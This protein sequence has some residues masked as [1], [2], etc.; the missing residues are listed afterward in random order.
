MGIND[1]P[2]PGESVYRLRGEASGD[3]VEGHATRPGLKATE[4][5]DVEGHVRRGL[6][7]T[8]DEEDVEGH[9]TRPGLK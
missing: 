3:D 9:A 4:D 1:R 5:E 2:G 7:A 8:E 6:K